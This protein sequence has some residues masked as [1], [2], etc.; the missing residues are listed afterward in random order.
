MNALAKSLE[1]SSRAAARV[2]DSVGE[3]RF[4]PHDGESDA[5]AAGEFNQL[6]NR[7]DRDVAASGLQCR[8]GI[9]RGDEN[10]GNP[11]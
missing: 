11:R 10:A 9:S 5:F 7:C 4:R 6:R 8:A 3:R 2:D 1:L